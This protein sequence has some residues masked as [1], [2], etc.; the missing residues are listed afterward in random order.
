MK[1]PFSQQPRLN[2]LVLH[3]DEDRHF[4]E[5]R[6]VA[7]LA[8]KFGA[9]ANVVY[10]QYD[11]PPHPHK[12]TV[13]NNSTLPDHL[14]QLRQMFRTDVLLAAH[15][16]GLSNVVVM[17]P[18]AVVIELFPR[19][20]RYY[21]YE[22]LSRVLM[23]HYTAFEGEIV[24]PAKCCKPRTSWTADS[25]L[26]PVE[27]SQLAR[28]DRWVDV[29]GWPPQG[30]QSHQ[31]KLATIAK[32]NGRR[33]CKGCDIV[34]DDLSMYQLIKNALATVWLRNSRLSNVHDFD[35]RR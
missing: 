11:S 1:T 22:E 20:F 7:F 35:V 18:G 2:V 26:V 33:E 21:M 6:V 27:A 17:Q 10:E 25:P 29:D 8:T 14:D 32:L 15:G 23:L 13:E 34:V 3:R 12:V 24:A 5:R 28:R 19:E 4:E 31:E 30:S 16:A 9:V